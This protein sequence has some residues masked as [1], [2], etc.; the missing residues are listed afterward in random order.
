MKDIKYNGKGVSINS[1]GSVIFERKD[2]GSQNVLIETSSLYK[3]TSFVCELNFS[4]LRIL[5][6]Q[7]NQELS[8]NRDHYWKPANPKGLINANIDIYKKNKKTGNINIKG[9]GYNDQN[10]GFVPIYHKI[11]GWNWGRFHSEKLN[12]IFFDIEY[13]KRIRRKVFQTYFI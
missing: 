1:P 3:K 8:K 10:W 13:K 5:N 7:I 11:S 9:S 12:G 2:D 6:N 4:P